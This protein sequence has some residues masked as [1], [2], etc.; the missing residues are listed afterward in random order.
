MFSFI[1]GLNVYNIMLWINFLH[2]YQ[3]ANSSL[4]RIQE[5]V[6]KSYARLIR[7]MEEHSHLN[8]TANISAC[9]LDRLRDEGY[10]DILNSLK[11]LV[12][13]GRLEL[14]GS[15]AYHAF[16]PYLPESEIIY[17]IKK[18]EKL[19]L[20]ILNVDVKGGGFFLPEMAYTPA[21]ARLVKK[22]GY[23][24]LILDEASLAPTLNNQQI[25][26]IDSNSGLSVIVRQRECSNTY[27]P[28]LI[29]NLLLEDKLP[30][31]IVTAT[32]AELYGLR[33]E[34]P[35]AELEKM[36]KIKNLETTTIT[37]YLNNSDKL[38]KLKFQT[39]S[40]ETNWQFDK[41]QP[42][43][44]WREKGNKTQSLLWDL[45]KLAIKA[46]QKFKN[47][48]NYTWCRWHL[49]R[50]LASCAFWWASGR[51][52]SHNFGPVAW[53][54][55]EVENGINDLLHSVRSLESEGSLKY[56]IKAEKLATKIKKSL[57][58]RHWSKHWL[59]SND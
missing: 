28:D 6:E 42:F 35:T 9:L 25:A 26:Y 2:L 36:V 23:K 51:N 46:E 29:N 19:T 12:K 48:S 5:A 27:V 49:D 11:A 22:M 30:N 54:P 16:L 21:L 33:H 47:D 44:I 8:F 45:A 10:I 40:W 7:L 43:V 39:A 38:S 52:F 4:E 53:N 3:P 31:I 14:V 56:K 34:D 1:V 17:Q 59:N 57:W 18:Q 37:N 32:D 58:L 20:E 41:G 24:W 50:G 15:A 13:S 55:D